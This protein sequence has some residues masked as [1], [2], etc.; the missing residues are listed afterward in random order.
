MNMIRDKIFN[1]QNKVLS[2]SEARIKVLRETRVLIKYFVFIFLISVLAVNWNHI[3]WLFN[4]KAVSEIASSAFEENIVDKTNEIIEKKEEK[5]PLKSFEPSDKENSLEIPKIEVSVPFIVVSSATQNDF[6]E[7]LSEGVVYFPDSVLPG[8]AGQTI[9]LGHSAPAGWPK[10]RYDWVFTRIS[11]LTAGDEIFV[12]FN[13]KKYIYY[14]TGK[15]FLDRGEEVP[16]PLTNY[17]NMLILISCWPPGKD[18][19]RIAMTAI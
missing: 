10:I 9:I 15:I 1:K 6:M 19:K 17:E 7:L 14:V 18:Y 5:P 16:K 11:E 3:S 13:H 8:E 2:S 4:Y 12:Y